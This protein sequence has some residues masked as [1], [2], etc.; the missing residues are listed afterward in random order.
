MK[1]LSHNLYQHLQ[2]IPFKI[3]TFVMQDMVRTARRLSTRNVWIDALCIVQD[4]VDDWARKSEHMGL[5]YANAF[6]TICALSTS[7]CLVSFLYCS[8]SVR[9]LFRSGVRADVQGMFK[10]CSICDTSLCARTWS[11]QKQSMNPRCQYWITTPVHGTTARGH[12]NNHNYLDRQWNS[13]PRIF[14]SGVPIDF[15]WS[16]GCSH[17]EKIRFPLSPG[18]L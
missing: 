14:I 15:G 4:D 3:M 11:T 1:T 2:G 7:S 12:T 17:R 13:V 5:V 16:P 9:M 10:A 8:L 18:V 6:V